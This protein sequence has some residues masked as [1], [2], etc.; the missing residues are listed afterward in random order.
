MDTNRVQKNYIHKVGG[1]DN[2]RVFD[3]APLFSRCLGLT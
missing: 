1:Y 3:D 2:L